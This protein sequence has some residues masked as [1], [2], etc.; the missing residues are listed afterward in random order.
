[1][2]KKSRRLR[3]PN[4]PPEAYNAPTAAAPVAAARASADAPAPQPVQQL[5]LMHEYKD[6]IR[7]LRR[8]FIIFACLV[9]VM[10]AG[11]FVLR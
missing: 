5:D 8:T 1:M 10:L 11:S 6:V 3:T 4:L 9:A 2:S 7:D